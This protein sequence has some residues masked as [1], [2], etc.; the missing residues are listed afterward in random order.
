MSHW[1]WGHAD[2][3][4]DEAA[5]RALGIQVGGL[6]GGDALD[7]RPLP[8]PE[9]I[10]LP[11]PRVAPPP[12]LAAFCS[13]DAAERA[14]HTYGKGYRDLVRGFS[15]DFS[16][17]PDLVARPRTE[18]EIEAALE[19]C[20]A[21]NV[22]L[23]PFGGGTSVV[24]GVEGGGGANRERF[25]GV[26]SLDLR[27]LDRVLE[28]DPISRAA[29]IQAGATGP[30]LEAQLVAHGLTL[31]HYPQSFE[32]STLG[33]W[34]ATRAGGHF[35][36]LATHIDDAVE[37]ARM[38][39][40]RGAWASLRL[41]ASGAGPSPDRMVLG[42]EG[43]LGVITEAWLR[44]HPRPTFRAGASVLFADF[45]AG[46]AAT[47]AIA[48]SGLHPA[49]CRLLDP[50]E[51]LLHRVGGDGGAVLLLAFESADHPLDAWIARALALAA[52]FGGRCPSGPRLRAGGEGDP[53]SAGET[54]RWRSAF[55][56]APYLQTALCSLGVLVDTF[57]TA[58]TWDRFDALHAA[59]VAAV[60]E[61]LR[62][63]AGGG[64][65]SCRFSHVYPDGPAPYYTFVGR[66]RDGEELAQWAE[67]KRAASDA[68]AAHGATITHHHAVGRVHRPWYD[69]QRPEPFALALR[70]AKAALDPAGIL[71][72]GVLID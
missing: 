54:D 34:I 9:A 4:P 69:R 43:I 28:V 60:E 2:Q 33:G 15:G 29:R 35:A 13:D 32:F 8:H 37:S 7:P 64:V 3:L 68:L 18:G 10:R 38:I 63:V 23:I 25:N 46:V 70:A 59:V 11:P 36:T 24:G 66:A 31:R 52:S 19:W 61:A 17:A 65:V 20:G 62:R 57:E 55:L 44:L 1:G 14:A 72:P 30:H 41:P 22:A 40:P 49:N 58:C 27:A 50:R 51:A 39:T 5:R 21:A 67:V 45:A 56:A 71:N 16:A 26:L 53:G 6:L 48:Q 12:S 42:S 47:R